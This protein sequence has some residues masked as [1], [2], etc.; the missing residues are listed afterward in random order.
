MAGS[1]I[2]LQKLVCPGADD[3]MKWCF[4]LVGCAVAVFAIVHQYKEEEKSFEIL[5]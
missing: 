5:F 4:V 3:Q 1:A 2:F